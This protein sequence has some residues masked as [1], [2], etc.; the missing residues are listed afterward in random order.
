MPPSDSDRFLHMLE[1][2]RDAVA[3]GSGRSRADLE[4]DRMLAYALVRCLEIIGEAA[5]RVSEVGRQAHPTIAWLQIRRMRNILSH[6]YFGIDLDVVWQTVR[7]DLPSLIATL[8]QILG[9]AT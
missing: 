5:T 3:F 7:E 9:E 4:S 8:E 2:A 6:V 1:A